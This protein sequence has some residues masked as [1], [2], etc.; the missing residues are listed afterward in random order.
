MKIFNIEQR[1]NK[2]LNTNQIKNIVNKKIS[3]IINNKYEV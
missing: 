1:F 2:N 3:N